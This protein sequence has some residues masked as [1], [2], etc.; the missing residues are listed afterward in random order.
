M[1]AIR[2]PA[3]RLLVVFLALSTTLAAANDCWA[4]APRYRVEETGIIARKGC[5]RGMNDL[6]V[7]CYW[8]DFAVSGQRGFVW[9]GEQNLLLEETPSHFAY[10]F[11]I[12]NSGRVAGVIATLTRDIAAIWDNC[13]LQELGTLGGRESW[14]LAVN[15]NGLV[16]GVSE[17][18]S[19]PV[20][21]FLWD[22]TF[23]NQGPLPAYDDRVL[24]I[25]NHNQILGVGGGMMDGWTWENGQ[26]TS[27][28]DLEGGH[29]SSPNDINDGGLVV[30]MSYINQSEQVAACWRDAEIS[31]LS[32]PD[33]ATGSN[34]YSVNELEQ[35]VGFC[36]SAE[37]SYREGC[38]WD[39]G[40]YYALSDC[41]ISDVDWQI[42][43]GFYTTDSGLILAEA[44][45]EGH[46][47][48]ELM[49]TP[50]PE[51]STLALLAMGAVGVLAY[52][53]RKRKRA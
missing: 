8:S 6:G 21:L 31:A 40:D 11:D 27:L 29:Y 32:R 15:D 10:P 23:H 19:G 42:T 25:N 33:W 14:A 22:G 43:R 53:W 7:A 35:I 45:A 28:P 34:A 49:L 48:Q 18:S 24:G 52:A 44:Y 39:D 51:P 4:S 38:L 9:D 47:W 41:I 36:S 13:V 17:M 16:A 2:F 46:G 26:Y 12:N 30:G 20:S 37:P 1:N 3:A 50:I 5:V